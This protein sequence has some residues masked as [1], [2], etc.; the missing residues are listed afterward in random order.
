MAVKKKKIKK[1]VNEE[2]ARQIRNLET[3]L[4]HTLVAIDGKH[5]QLDIIFKEQADRLTKELNLL[6]ENSGL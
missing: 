4:R 1:E 5:E 6:K 3:D 2:I